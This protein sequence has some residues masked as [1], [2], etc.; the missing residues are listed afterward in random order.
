MHFIVTQTVHPYL[1]QVVT[2]PPVYMDW[3][4]RR[5]DE[6]L[7]DIARRRA[8][9]D[10]IEDGYGIVNELTMPG[11]GDRSFFTVE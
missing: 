2:L 8:T 3:A 10:W 6:L 5:L 11:F 7:T 4:R 9:G 1:T